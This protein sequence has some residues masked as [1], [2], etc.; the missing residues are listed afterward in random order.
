MITSLYVSVLLL[1]LFV[2]IG[3][4]NPTVLSCSQSVGPTHWDRII[5]P[6]WRDPPRYLTTPAVW[7][8]SEAG[9]WTEFDASL[10]SPKCNIPRIPVTDLSPTVFFSHYQEPQ[11]PVIIVGDLNN[12]TQLFRRMTTKD[13]LLS[14]FEAT[15]ITLSTANKN[16][17]EKRTVRFD[18][19]VKA[20]EEV[21]RADVTGADTMYHFGN[22]NHQEWSELFDA[23][24]PPRQYL[25]EGQHISYSF[26]L[27]GSGTGVPFHTHGP[28]FAD[29]Q[30]GMKRWFLKAPSREGPP[31]DPDASM[32]TWLREVYPTLD[33]EREGIVE[34][35]CHPG[36]TIYIPPLWHHATLNIGQTV[37]MSSFV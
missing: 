5:P 2:V 18:E 36:D 7:M 27:A 20:M 4:V 8:D 17:Y 32:L 10:Y 13:S 23:Y 19:Y 24:V 15:T 14:L 16:S 22:N 37:F 9:V 30:W 1:L 31:S 28:V 29:V 35:V 25:K 26:G 21:Q 33:L 3:T 34:C 11:L 6:W 12:G